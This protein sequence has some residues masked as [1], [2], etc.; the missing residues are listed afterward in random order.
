MSSLPHADVQAFLDE[1]VESE[2]QGL[3]YTPPRISQMIRRALPPWGTIE[4]VQVAHRPHRFEMRR[5]QH[6]FVLYRQGSVSDGEV[7]IDGLRLAGPR[8]L[9]Q[10]VDFIP[11]GALFEGWTGERARVGYVLVSVDEDQLAAVCPTYRVQTDLKPLISCHDA[12][13]RGLLERLDQVVHGGKTDALYLETLVMLLMQ[14][15]RALQQLPEVVPV[16]TGEFGPVQRQRLTDYIEASLADEVRLAD[17]SNIVNLSPYHFSR[18]FRRTFG[19]SPYQYLLLCRVNRAKHL[20]TTT[21]R[22]LLDIALDTGF[23]G[24]SQFSRAFRR[25][26]GQAASQLRRP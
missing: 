11:A 19:M 22:S 23:A 21:D 25:I 17:L 1:A 2:P 9:D 16:N 20:I 7:S 6:Q 3:T 4:C 12:F 13:L 15:V 5:S 10:F 8:A 18:V 14:E 26:V 24:A